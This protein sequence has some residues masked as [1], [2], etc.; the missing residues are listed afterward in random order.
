MRAPKIF[1]FAAASVL[2]TACQ[3]SKDNDQEPLI[4]SD[5]AVSI[6]SM[7]LGAF[8]QIGEMESTT[9]S[10]FGG[11]AFLLSSG[12]EGNFKQAVDL[13]IC[14]QGSANLD[15]NDG[16][17]LGDIAQQ[18]FDVSLQFQDCAFQTLMIDGAYDFNFESNGG[19]LS[20]MPGGDFTLNTLQTFTELSLSES[21]SNFQAD[22]NGTIAS[23]L[24][25][26]GDTISWDNTIDLDLDS[27]Q[28]VLSFEQ[29]EQSLN[30]D[31]TNQNI[32]VNIDGEFS[33]SSLNASFDFQ[34]ME[35]LVFEGGFNLLDPSAERVLSGQFKVVANDSSSVTVTIINSDEAQLEI[36]FN[37]D[38]VVDEL[39]IVPLDDLELFGIFSL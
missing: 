14:E 36:S 26:V 1:L 19:L 15:I 12:I 13:P 24:T 22:I 38:G 27:S 5:T 35:P 6:V 8:E 28:G 30:L 9:D 31:T 4:K 21:S 39:I 16:I 11:D 37:N 10:I 23:T 34:M 20:G 2:L 7:S 3:E 17:D 33:A 25:K 29:W 32:S 18:T